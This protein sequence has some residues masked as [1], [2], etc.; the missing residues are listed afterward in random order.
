MRKRMKLDD[1]K[2]NEVSYMSIKDLAFALGIG[3]H[4]ANRAIN[5][6]RLPMSVRTDRPIVSDEVR[7]H[8]RHYNETRDGNGAEIVT[9]K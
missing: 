9:D 3:F 1:S 8:I 6:G 4:V 2:L 5:D 7:A